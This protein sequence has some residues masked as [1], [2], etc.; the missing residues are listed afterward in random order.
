MIAQAI[1]AEFYGEPGQQ[2]TISFLD[3]DDQPGEIPLTFAP[4]PGEKTEITP[5]LPPAHVEF[6]AYRLTPEIGYLGFSGFLQGVDEDAFT[7]IDEM[8]D[9][10]TLIIDLR[11]NPGG[12]FPVRKAIAEKLAGERVLF[13]R[14]QQRDRLETV[15]LEAMPTAYEGGLVILIDELSASSSEEFAGGLQAIGRA[16]IVGGHSPGR[17]PTAIIMPLENGAILV[18]PYG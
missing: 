14:Y 18:Y 13:W 3:N 16:T 17:T 2:A 7:A 6:S 11:G 10:G 12:V 15:Y 8:M 4:R 9:T 5:D 1:R